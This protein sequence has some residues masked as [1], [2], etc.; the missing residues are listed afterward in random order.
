MGWIFHLPFLRNEVGSERAGQ[1]DSFTGPCGWLCI[2]DGPHGMNPSWRVVYALLA[3]TLVLPI[4]LLRLFF[5]SPSSYDEWLRW[6]FVK[7]SDMNL[8]VIT[9]LP[10][11]TFVVV[12]ARATMR[13]PTE[14][15]SKSP[16][17]EE[18]WTTLDMIG[19]A[20]SFGCLGNVAT[21]HFI[22]NNM[23]NFLALWVRKS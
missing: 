14:G 7:S 5:F 8:V 9:S 10:S 11:H 1:V 15:G 23:H 17:R 2:R 3:L 22:R 18:R 21:F 20:L 13:L 16:C 19:V 12:L 4:V 6:P